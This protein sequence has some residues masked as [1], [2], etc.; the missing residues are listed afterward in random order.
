MTSELQSL[1]SVVA[2]A[3]VVAAEAKE[4]PIEEASTALQAARSCLGEGLLSYT[5]TADGFR[6]KLRPGA[7]VDIEAVVTASLTVLTPASLGNR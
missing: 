6:A 3:M 1:L 7:L 5:S 2:C 4:G